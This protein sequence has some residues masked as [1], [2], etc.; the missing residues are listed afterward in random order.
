MSADPWIAGVVAP[1][2][3]EGPKPPPMAREAAAPWSESRRVV[4][5]DA[6]TAE[7]RVLTP[8]ERWAIEQ[9]RRRIAQEAEIVAAVRAGESPVEIGRRVGLSGDAVQRIARSALV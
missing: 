6:R 5:H 3:G 8:A 7:S 2:L 9:R 1:L 4:W